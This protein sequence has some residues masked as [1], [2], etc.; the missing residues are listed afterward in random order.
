ML[1]ETVPPPPSPSQSELPDPAALA[2]GLSLPALVAIVVV[3]LL[4]LLGTIRISFSK[5]SGIGALRPAGTTNYR[6]LLADPKFFGS[7]RLTL[8]F[9]FVVAFGVMLL[10]TLTAVS[11]RRGRTAAFLRV[12]WFLPAIV[13]GT[14]MAVFWG[15]AFQPISGAGSG[16]LGR[17]GLGS[18]R[19]WLASPA[20]ARWAVMGVAIWAGV[21]F[22]FLIIVG[23]IARVSPDLYE[24]AEIDGAT[25]RRQLWHI[26]LPLIQPVLVMLTVLEVIW[27]FNSFTLIWAMRAAA[28]SRARRRCRCGSTPRRSVTSTTARR[29]RSA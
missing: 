25:G 22:P 13:P 21:A 16:V 23:A 11:V 15:F 18:D 2:I 26:T 29:R 1:P 12:V 4:P 28:R 17:L 3:Y 10:A 5:W 20:A 6:K 14:A 7:L 8:L 24:A 19:A 27:N 9:A